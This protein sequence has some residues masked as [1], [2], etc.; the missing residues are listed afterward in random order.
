MADKNVSVLTS[1]SY[2]G[3]QTVREFEVTDLK[4]EDGKLN[5]TAVG[6]VEK[7]GTGIVDKVRLSFTD[8]PFEGVGGGSGDSMYEYVK[9]ILTRNQ[10]TYDDYVYS[11][12]KTWEEIEAAVAGGKQLI[13]LVDFAEF[14]DGS[15]HKYYWFPFTANTEYVSDG[16]TTR[17]ALYDIKGAIVN[18]WQTDG[19]KFEISIGT[20][21]WDVMDPTSTGELTYKAFYAE[22][23]GL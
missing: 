14:L 21:V 18:A 1:G 2:T 5:G 7:E 9:I 22:L 19:G 12:D 10:E 11:C 8:V 16:E 13:G 15:T 23:Q 17:M 3:S 20:Y 4:V 6:S